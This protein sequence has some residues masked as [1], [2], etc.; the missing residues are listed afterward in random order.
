[1]PLL[2][3]NRMLNGRMYQGYKMP[4]MH[5]KKQL[6]CP[7]DSKKYLQ[8]VES[9]GRVS[10]YMALQEQVK[11]FW[12]KPALQKLREPFFLYHRQT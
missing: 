1:M 6:Y 5:S 4:K 9:L 2:L 10:Y 12:P 11:H 8:V 7:L 3:K